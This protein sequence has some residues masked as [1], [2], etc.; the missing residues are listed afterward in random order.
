MRLKTFMRQLYRY[1]YP[2]REFKPVAR[3]IISEHRWREMESDE[4]ERAVV[5]LGIA[6]TPLHARQLLDKYGVK[7]AADLAQL[8]P[9]KNYET[10]RQRIVR[11]I[12]K[13]DGH[14][15]GDPYRLKSRRRQ[16]PTL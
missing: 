6:R 10:A 3:Q 16:P 5:Q 15:D 8:I 1:I 9:P 13:L 7:H 2:P 14:Q 11:L 12:R 4:Q